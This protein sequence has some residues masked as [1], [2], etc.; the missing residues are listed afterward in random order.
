MIHQRSM[1]LRVMS[2]HI[3]RHPC[4]STLFSSTRST[5]TPSTSSCDLTPVLRHQQRTSLRV[6]RSGLSTALGRSR[7]HFTSQS[8]GIARAVAS[9]IISL[10]QLF[11]S[12]FSF[13][14]D[15]PT[16][17]T[18]PHPYSRQSQQKHTKPVDDQVLRDCAT[19]FSSV[20]EEYA[21]W[22]EDTW[23]EGTIPADLHGTYFR[24]GPGIQINSERCQRH[25]F[26]GDGMVFSL[27]F[28][29]GRA[30]FRNR[31]VRT[32]GFVQEQAA[33][34]P[35]YRTTFSS[36]AADGSPLF[37]PLDLS[38]KNVANTG[39]V[40]WAG[41]LYALWEAGKPHE[42]DPRTLETIG[43]SD[44]DG[45]LHGPL[46]GHY[47]L[48]R[49]KDEQQQRWITFGTDV[50]FGGL[51]ARFYEHDQAGRCVEQS[52]HS[53]PGIDITF[54][55][56][57]AVT[58]NYYV[59]VLGPIEFDWWRFAS[60][61][62]FGRCSIAQCLHYNKEGKAKAMLF[63][64]PG[65][66]GAAQRQPVVV[67]VPRAFFP[68]HNVN[69]YEEPGSSR[70]VID[71]VGWSDVDFDINRFITSPEYYQGGCRPQYLRVV[72][73]TEN[74]ET[75][76]VQPML[77][78]RTVEFPM[79]NPA[80]TGH[81]HSYVYFTADTVGH[82]HLWGPAQALIQVQLPQG[83]EEQGWRDSI[84]TESSASTHGASTS[85]S[86]IS[87]QPN[88]IR[89]Q[90]WL[91]GPRSFCGESMVVPR[92]GAKHEL[93]A[94]I[95]VGV[96][97]AETCTADIVILDAEHVAAGPVATI[98]LPHHLPASL[99]GSFSHEYLGPDPDDT[100]VPMWAEPNLVRAL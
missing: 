55:H 47:R 52:Q 56:D 77:Q 59:L 81:R 66:P 39:I 99:H 10:G 27:A 12:H 84:S 45:L 13:A 87:P 4:P 89:V 98:H 14:P 75:V 48:Y 24:N 61:Y 70:V 53:L 62:I 88:G 58:E 2:A 76:S 44:M 72:L 41:K 69:A 43:E 93:D 11:P 1:A 7:L 94:W 86:T 33:G 79:I 31:F 30:F 16:T 17:S 71:T 8:P 5:S 67:P 85:T 15:E 3:V 22:V 96:H 34:K 6:P 50:T 42:L 63:P 36:G 68:F 92:P 83:A 90:Q 40:H 49:D 9:D 65:R 25:A 35:L 37:N 51:T 91:P 18:S 95:I 32:E 97:N 64:R 78:E 54:V 74:S 73:D 23:I 29:D 20:L 28:K 60:Q 19:A 21:Y 26:D 80:V 46:A 57:M 82:Q 38:F 100:N